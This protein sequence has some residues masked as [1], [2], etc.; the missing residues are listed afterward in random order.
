MIGRGK[1]IRSHFASVGHVSG[2][3]SKTSYNTRAKHATVQICNIDDD[4][5]DEN[6]AEEQDAVCLTILVAGYRR[7][8]QWYSWNKITSA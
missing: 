2:S 5:D 8:W 4:G 1:M 3:K 7:S 6:E